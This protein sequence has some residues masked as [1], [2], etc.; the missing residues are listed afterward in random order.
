MASIIELLERKYKNAVDNITTQYEKY[1][2]LRVSAE[3]ITCRTCKSKLSKEYLRK[4]F[5]S[6][7]KPIFGIKRICCPVCKDMNSLY[8]KTANERI[9]AAEKKA[10]TIKVQLFEARKKA[11]EKKEKSPKKTKSLY[12]KACKEVE[13][14]LEI[15]Y[16]IVK[17]PDFTEYKGEIGG[18]VL[19]MRAYKDGYVVEK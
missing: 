17:T 5:Y 13:N 14:R 4:A 10:G 16:E 1:D 8:S 12:E 18:D 15:I 3:F 11:I 6:K 7:G 9:A 19:C 2:P